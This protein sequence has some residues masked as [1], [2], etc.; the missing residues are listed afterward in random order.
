MQCSEQQGGGLGDGGWTWGRG[1]EILGR[2]MV[3]RRQWSKAQPKLTM[4]ETFQE[5]LLLWDKIKN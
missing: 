3:K 2:E 1:D 4:Y 5:N